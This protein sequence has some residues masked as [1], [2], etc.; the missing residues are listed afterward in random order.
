MPQRKWNSVLFFSQCRWGSKSQFSSTKTRPAASCERRGLINLETLTNN[1]SLL[2]Q[3]ATTSVLLARWKATWWNARSAGE[4]TD[5]KMHF[6]ITCSRLTRTQDTSR[7]MSRTT[8]CSTLR[9]LVVS[10]VTID[11]SLCFRCW[12]F[13]VNS[14]RVI[15]SLS[16]VNDLYPGA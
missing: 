9:P 10:Y 4:N 14:C 16:L 6:G 11:T 2:S 5:T 8:S 12:C 13:E 15:T 1:P 7:K 3:S